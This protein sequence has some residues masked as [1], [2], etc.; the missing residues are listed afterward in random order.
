MLGK[1]PAALPSYKHYLK[2]FGTR[3]A[4]K[5]GGLRP[6]FWYFLNVQKVQVQPKRN[7]SEYI[8]PID[9]VLCGFGHSAGC[10]GCG[11]RICRTKCRGGCGRKW[12]ASGSVD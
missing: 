3:A 8:A 7:N 1:M 11:A 10:V 9:S 12:Y 6:F 4:A 2:T 5:S